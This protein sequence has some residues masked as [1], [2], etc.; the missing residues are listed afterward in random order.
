VLIILA[1][2]GMVLTIDPFLFLEFC[3]IE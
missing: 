1:C 2:N 3:E